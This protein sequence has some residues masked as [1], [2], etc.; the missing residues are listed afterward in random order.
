MK[1]KKK[2]RNKKRKKRVWQKKKKG[3]GSWHSA[4][5]AALATS[6][7]INDGHV[8]IKLTPTNQQISRA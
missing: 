3:A 6:P 7:A 1:R 8:S 5:R 4:A 2:Q